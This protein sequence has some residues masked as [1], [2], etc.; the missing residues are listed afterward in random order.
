[1]RTKPANLVY[2]LPNIFTSAS[3]FSGVLSIISAV[4]G[5]FSKAA[6]LILLALIFDGLD[7]RVAR[8]TNTCSRFGVEFDSLADI[9]SF[10]VAPSIL[11]Y[12][13][14][15]ND[16][17]RLG[18]AA[19]A[20]FVIFGAIRLARFNVMTSKAEPSV[21]IGVPIPTAAVFISL[22]VLLFQKY[23][24]KADYGAVIIALSI[25]VS[26]LMVSNIRYPSFKKLDY[27]PK[28][29]MKLFIVIL[30]MSLLIFMFPIEGF[31]LLFIV[32]I[33]Y[34]PIRALFL[35]PKYLSKKQ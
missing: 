27:S 7:G 22:L 15:G 24:F 21:F 9:V 6:W 13:F 33:L 12:L 1:M 19:S 5:E 26:L 25:I 8:L 18:I 28:H 10:G 30:F 31:S 4:N 23:G 32:Y 3:I 14:I 16:F 11:M 34:G 20:L 17:G 2:I 35:L 29:V